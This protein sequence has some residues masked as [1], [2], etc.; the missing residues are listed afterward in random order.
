[1]RFV[2]VAND[3]KKVDV[4][5]I[6]QLFVGRGLEFVQDLVLLFLKK[7][8]WPRASSVSL[9]AQREYLSI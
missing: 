9:I 3:A 5:N 7:C 2:Y 8:L 6:P 1:M 4:S